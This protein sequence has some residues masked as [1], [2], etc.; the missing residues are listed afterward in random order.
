MPAPFL[1]KGFPNK[2]Q[3]MIL[4]QLFKTSRVGELSPCLTLPGKL[5]FQETA[6][7]N[8]TLKRI[9]KKQNF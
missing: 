8:L 6:G 4:R 9:V 3:S 7:Y 5:I 2:S 1:S